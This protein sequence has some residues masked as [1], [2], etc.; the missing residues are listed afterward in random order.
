MTALTADKKTQYTEGVE[1]P[2]P[3]DGGSKIFAGANVCFNAAGFLV[4]G[5]D[6]TG[7]IYAGVSRSSIDNS[8]GQDGDE[9]AVVRRRGLYLMEFATAITQANVGD[10]VFLVDDQLVDLAG[11]VTYDIFCGIIA[12]YVDTT[13]AFV[14]ILPAILQA[15]VA[16]HIADPSGAHAASAISTTDAGNHFAAAEATVEQQ[17]QKLGKGPFFLTLPRFTGWTKDG[18]DKTITLPAIESPNPVVVK[19]AYANLGT[20]PGTG[21]TLAL[22]L[23]DTA[24]LSIAED[25]TQGEAENLSIAIA[26]DTD[27]VIKANETAD[28]AGANCDIT[29]VMYIDDGE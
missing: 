6:A 4:P 20:A 11:N 7:L 12:Q 8:L 9:S 25:A 22:K 21:K 23:N 10:N 26:K 29:L 14:D 13:H 5:E 1:V 3:V 17:L 2:V 27:F 28:G 24:L 16:S 18:T 15:D 19:R